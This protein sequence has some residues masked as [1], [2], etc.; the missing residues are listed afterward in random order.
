MY[1]SH[2]YGFEVV[3]VDSEIICL[4]RFVVDACND[5]SVRT[6]HRYVDF[7]HSAFRC[8]ELALKGL[9]TCAFV[10]YVNVNIDEL[11]LP[12]GGPLNM[13]GARVR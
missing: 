5:R 13:G 8:V 11:Y 10:C 6:T 2:K 12:V 9:S 3:R 4:A 1:N 7:R